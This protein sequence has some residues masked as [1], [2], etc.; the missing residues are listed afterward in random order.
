MQWA[1]RRH[2][3]TLGLLPPLLFPLQAIRNSSR[4]SPDMATA[5]F[6]FGELGWCRLGL[7][8]PPE[9][10]LVSLGCAVAVR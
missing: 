4:Y 9:L 6:V 7:L 10:C 2:G 1:Q 5:D 3:L 8:I